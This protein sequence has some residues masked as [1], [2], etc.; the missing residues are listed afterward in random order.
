MLRTSFRFDAEG[1]RAYNAYLSEE[2]HSPGSMVVELDAAAVRAMQ[3]AWAT[4]GESDLVRGD[5]CFYNGNGDGCF[6]KRRQLMAGARDQASSG[7]PVPPLE[8]RFA[9][10]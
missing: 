10:Q 5:G 1:A 7:S 2:K 9:P 6:Y 4:A 8:R 3:D